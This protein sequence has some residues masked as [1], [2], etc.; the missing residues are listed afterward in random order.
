MLPSSCLDGSVTPVGPGQ[1]P[2]YIGA[3]ND[4]RLWVA[5][6]DSKR[7]HNPN[8]NKNEKHQK[9]KQKEKREKKKKK[10]QKKSKKNEKSKNHP[11]FQRK[12]T[13]QINPQSAK[14]KKKTS[15]KS[16]FK[17]RKKRRPSRGYL[18]ETTL[19]MFFSRDVARN[20]AAIHVKKRLKQ[21]KENTRT[22]D[23]QGRTPPF[24]RLTCVSFFLFKTI[25]R[26]FKKFQKLKMKESAVFF[27]FFVSSY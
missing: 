1:N 12:K 15:K 23:T 16:K 19:K 11:I 3:V 5:H 4:G 6:M 27:L 9:I 2:Q 18:P 22:L 10:K 20:R 21:K 24:R 26:F 25:N 8:K 13:K 14:R 7:A 17:A